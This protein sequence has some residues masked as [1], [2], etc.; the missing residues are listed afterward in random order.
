HT[1]SKR[2]WS[3]DVCS[4]DLAASFRHIKNSVTQQLTSELPK[5]L[6]NCSEFI[7]EDSNFS[8]LHVDLNEEMNRRMAV[9]M[10]NFVNDNLKSTR[11]E[12]RRVGK[13]CG[14]GE[15]T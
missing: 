4:S 8:T 5:L 14:R 15:L 7:E 11:S 12:E 10:K 6:Q 3:S 2:D 13:E 9:Y 1:R